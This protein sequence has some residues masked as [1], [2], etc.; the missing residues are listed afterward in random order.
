MDINKLKD[1]AQKHL[2]VIVFSV[3]IIKN[4]LVWFFLYP[5][6]GY[7]QITMTFVTVLNPVIAIIFIYYLKIDLNKIG[8]GVKKLSQA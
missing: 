6:V 5:N 4:F 8:L 1:K 2:I 3:F 7:N